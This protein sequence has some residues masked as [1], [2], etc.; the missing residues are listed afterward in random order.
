MTVM[1]HAAAHP[2]MR[3][4]EHAGPSISEM[5][6]AFLAAAW[7]RRYVIA[8][9]IVLLPVLGAVAGRFAP[10]TYEARMSVLIQEPG[11]LNPFLEDLSV[12]TN[13]K[14]RMDGLR[15]LL[16]SRHVL[17]SVAEDI[18]LVPPKAPQLALDKAVADLAASVSVQLIGNEMVE[19]HYRSNSASGVAAVLTR[20]GERFIER[21][22][23]PEN[24]S[25][26]ESV[27][28]LQRQLDDATARM[29]T[30]ED[31]LATFKAANA[32]QLPDL[33]ASNIQRLAQLRDS[34][35]DHEIRLSGAESE[36]G[37]M[38]ARM[39]QTDPVVGRI[40]QDIVAASGELAQLR[41]RYTE[42]HSAVQG[43]ARKLAR[44]QQEHAELIRE[45]EALPPADPDRL[46]N[47]AA[48]SAGRQDGSAPLLVS[49]LGL[50][51]AARNRLQVLRSETANLREAV[52]EL[53]QR[54]QAS[55]EV[56]RGLRARE[57]EVQVT[58]D[59]VSQLRR[60]FEMARV[61]GDLS[62]YQEP[63]RI[64]IIDR[65][66]EPSGPVRP[67]TLLFTIG[68]LVGGIVLGIGLAVMLEIAD[69]SVRR[70]RD[71]ERLTGVPVLARI[72][73]LSHP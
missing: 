30:A 73:P 28:F 18:G 51:E 26:R 67:I 9:P 27:V 55:S 53:D 56:E 66:V 40:E 45:S 22:E 48:A 46:W 25:I 52:K 43:V 61:T 11:K 20:I 39:A 41:A 32:Q 47:L 4:H 5:L 57:R 58:G 68:G 16:T 23:A 71:M 44:L 10:R 63:Q 15:A 12:K 70:I 38:R 72:M 19:L 62:R 33:R 8:V 29:E 37:A 13:L 54:V 24:S 1:S 35:S 31:S 42:E 6:H 2:A 69:T 17:G 64:A 3:G 34:L 36:F 7:R 60:R 59:L 49:Q 14:D 50:L 65:P 21:V